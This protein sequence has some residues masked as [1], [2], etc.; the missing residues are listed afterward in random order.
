[1][2]RTSCAYSAEIYR[3]YIMFTFYSTVFNTENR[4]QDIVHIIFIAQSCT[5]PGYLSYT[6]IFFLFYK[7][8][9]AFGQIIWLSWLSLT[10]S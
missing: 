10:Q 1:M 2:M 9:A 4:K 3:T 5:L 7:L 6:Y 8:S